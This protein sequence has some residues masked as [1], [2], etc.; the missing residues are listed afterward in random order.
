MKRKRWLW[1]ALGLAALIFFLSRGHIH[2][3][4][5]QAQ[6]D[7]VLAARIST[8]LQANRQ[9]LD[10][11]D[12]RPTLLDLAGK[13]V[14]L[15]GEEHGLATMEELD[16]AMLRYLHRAAGVRVYV[17][18]FGYAMGHM[19]NRY[20]DSGDETV[21]ARVIGEARRTMSW[22]KE[23]RAFFVKL[24]EWNQTLAPGERVRFAGVDIEHQHRLALRYLDDLA[25]Q[26][27]KARPEIREM[28]ARLEWMASEPL[29]QAAAQNI[30]QLAASVAA[31]REAY[32]ELVGG[33]FVDF[34]LVA[35]NL[36]RTVDYYDYH[37]KP[38]AFAI[39]ERA[40][41]ENFRK[42]YARMGGGVWYGRWGAFHIYQR[43]TEN[44]DRFAA[45][46]NG[47]ESPVAGKVVSIYPLYW[48]AEGMG[49]DYKPRTFTTDAT[50]SLPFASA[51]LPDHI[52][53]FRLDGTDSPFRQRVPGFLQGEG[54][55]SD[56]AQ[57]V[58]LI[59]NAAP[60]HALEP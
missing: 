33:R 60:T 24:R 5:P 23:R 47:A 50:T 36:A 52:T 9:A 28:V 58:A 44:L 6:W 3:G 10:L 51:A 7:P 54:M 22:T 42:V 27:S 41:Y 43:R 57:Y 45:L 46:L 26:R 31:H 49:Q 13:R 25:W 38:Q 39:R 11:A 16:L 37:G 30:R 2:L 19:L 14:I 21:L 59:R 35:E 53:L 56:L 48:H 20:L 34:E 17:G 32:A 18:E 55:P 12:L 40:I 15:L 29:S 1:A 8:Y 4:R